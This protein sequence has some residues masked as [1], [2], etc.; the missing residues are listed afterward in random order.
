V[1]SRDR[2]HDELLARS[3]ARTVGTSPSDEERLRVYR[4]LLRAILGGDDEKYGLAIEALNG[5]G[6]IPEEDAA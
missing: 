2:F 6:E 4:I 3:G 1:S 5:L